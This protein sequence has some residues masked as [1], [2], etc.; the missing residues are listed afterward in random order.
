MVRLL[1]AGHLS[2][3]G[4]GAQMSGAQICFLAEDEGLKWGLS[5]KLCCFC[6]PHALLHR[7]GSH[8]YI[9]L[10]AIGKCY[11]RKSEIVMKSRRQK[12]TVTRDTLRCLILGKVKEPIYIS[13]AAR[14]TASGQE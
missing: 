13:S 6:S 3:D 9:F 7:L 4:K 5:Q 2:S 8:D 14:D 10:I 12:N 11:S 1:S